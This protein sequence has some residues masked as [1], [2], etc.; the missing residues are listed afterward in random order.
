MK[1]EPFAV[2]NYGRVA[3]FPPRPLTEAEWKRMKELGVY[4]DVGDWFFAGPLNGDVVKTVFDTF[5]LEII[6]AGSEYFGD[7]E[8]T[9][10]YD[11]GKIRVWF[12]T[13]L[14]KDDY[15]DMRRKGFR[16]VKPEEN[17]QAPYSASREDYLREKYG[18]EHLGVDDTDLLA[19]AESRADF[20]SNWAD[21]AGS[22]AASAFKTAHDIGS[23]IPFGQ[24]ILV[25]HH[26]EK[27]H[28]RDI[29]RIDRNMRAGTEALG[30]QDHWQDRSAATISHAARRYEKRPLANRL[31][32]LEADLRKALSGRERIDALV[33]TETDKEFFALLDAYEIWL[34]ENLRENPWLTRP[35]YDA[36]VNRSNRWIAFLRN[37]IVVATALYAEVTK[38][39]KE[40]V[41][42]VGGGVEWRGS[43]WHHIKR[44]NK[45][46]VTVDDWLGCL[47]YKIPYQDITNSMSKAV[48]EGAAEKAK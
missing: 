16:W 5:G 27:R 14:A 29:D 19:V 13:R 22:K 31:E 21:N 20:Y 34:P 38:D 36:F 39:D 44:V 46:T 35:F 12:P 7:I 30:R 25:G 3:F 26:S 9:I 41:F 8:A 43:G 2:K 48:W 37:R 10:N 18:V 6:P 1:T 42:E 23:Y 33:A 45:K 11:D 47:E 32:R 40:L 28:R 4:L 15:Q 24:P 17:F